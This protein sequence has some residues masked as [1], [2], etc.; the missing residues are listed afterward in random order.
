MFVVFLGQLRV[1]VVLGV[2]LLF[3]L[4]DSAELV[5]NFMV[6]VFQQTLLESLDGLSVFILSSQYSAFSR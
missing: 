3:Q 4:F 5:F 6:A 2:F 1:N